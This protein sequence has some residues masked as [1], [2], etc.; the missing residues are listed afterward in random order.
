MNQTQTAALIAAPLGSIAL[1]VLL[2]L[3]WWRRRKPPT[4]R[5]VETTPLQDRP[6]MEFG[7]NE[8]PPAPAPSSRHQRRSGLR[9]SLGL[10]SLATAV[11]PTGANQDHR[12]LQ[13]HPVTIPQSAFQSDSSRRSTSFRSA[14]AQ[15]A[16]TLGEAWGSGPDPAQ[17]EPM[18]AAATPGQEHAHGGVRCSSGS[19]RYVAAPDGPHRAGPSAAVSVEAGPPS[20]REARGS[21]HLTRWSRR[22]DSDIYFVP[23]SP[24][25]PGSDWITPIGR[26]NVGPRKQQPGRHW[27]TSSADEEDRA[28]DEKRRSS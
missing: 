6:P 11:S 13:S 12:P 5:S 10:A 21:W 19:A 1:A 15:A 7:E 16:S 25:R 23:R 9:R 4:E 20:P 18:L 28:D 17:P 22:K 3:F 8:P 27:E 14:R 24:T 2:Y 26:G